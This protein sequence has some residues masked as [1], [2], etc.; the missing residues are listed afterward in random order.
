MINQKIVD[1]IEEL[2]NTS[3]NMPKVWDGRSAILEM[4]DAGSRQ[5]RA[6]GMDGILL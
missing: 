1:T 2:R 3:R 6:D 4:K 5:W